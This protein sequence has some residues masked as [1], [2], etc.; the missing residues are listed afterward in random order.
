MLV[1]GNAVAHPLFFGLDTLAFQQ[2]KLI[3]HLKKYFIISYLQL[4]TVVYNSLQQIL[5]QAVT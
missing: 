5:Q 1:K 4:F 3:F 2:C